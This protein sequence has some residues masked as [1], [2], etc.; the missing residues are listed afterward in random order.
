MLG[1]RYR[2]RLV[3][4]V[5]ADRIAFVRDLMD[6]F[7]VRRGKR[8]DTASLIVATFDANTQQSKQTLL[9]LPL[10]HHHPPTAGTQR[11]S[12]S[13]VARQGGYFHAM[14]RLL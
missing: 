8:L 11:S 14:V 9:L 5:T 10:H 4:V 12:S 6:R 7:H 13:N 2:N 1:S 3:I